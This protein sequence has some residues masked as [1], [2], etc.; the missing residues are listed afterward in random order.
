MAIGTGTLSY[1]PAPCHGREMLPDFTADLPTDPVG[2]RGATFLPLDC[3]TGGP[4][5][6]MTLGNSNMENEAA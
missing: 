4:C 3:V 5:R 2:K 1:M 6:E